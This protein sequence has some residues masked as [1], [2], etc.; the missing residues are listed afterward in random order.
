MDRQLHE[1]PFSYPKQALKLRIEGLQEEGLCV[2]RCG[3]KA[4]PLLWVIVSW[5]CLSFG[6]KRDS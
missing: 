6:L 2:T 5:V 1:N 3:A 4:R